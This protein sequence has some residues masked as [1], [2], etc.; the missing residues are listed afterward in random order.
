MWSDSGGFWGSQGVLG[1][2]LMSEAFSSMAW[3]EES[4]AC[5]TEKSFSPAAAAA[6][7]VATWRSYSSYGGGRKG[8]GQ[9]QAP[10]PFITSLITPKSVTPHSPKPLPLRIHPF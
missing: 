6:F 1:L 10:P 8:R 7:M 4:S 2:T 3:R 9:G 5:D